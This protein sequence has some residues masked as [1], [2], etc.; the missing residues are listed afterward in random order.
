VVASWPSTGRTPTS[1]PGDIF[2]VEADESDG[3]V[4]RLPARG[5]RRHQR[6]TRPPR[7]ST[8]TSRRRGGIPGLRPARSS[9][10]APRRVSPTTRGRRPRGRSR[11][12]RG[13]GC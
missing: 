4:P 1:G 12:R 13:S 10:V 6:P 5:R 8:A 2:V 9:R 7:S 11:A 3:S